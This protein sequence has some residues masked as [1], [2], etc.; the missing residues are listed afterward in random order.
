M[1]KGD[2]V[3]S[4][5]Q[6]YL[7]FLPLFFIV[8]IF[9]WWQNAKNIES[10]IALQGY[11]PVAYV[12]QK[13]EPENFGRN[14]PNAVN[15]YDKS[16]F[17]HI[18]LLVYKYL[19]IHPENL[20]PIIIGFE[21]AILSLAVYFLS[22]C[23]FPGQKDVAMLAAILIIASNV[24]EM[25]FARYG[26]PGTLGLM[27][28]YYVAESMRLFAIGM[29]LKSRT[30]VASVLLASSY[31]TYPSFGIV[32]A[33]FIFPILLTAKKKIPSIIPAVMSFLFIVLTWTLTA[34]EM[35]NFSSTSIPAQSWFDLTKLNSYHLYP[36]DYGL[37]T[38]KHEERFIQFLSFIL[39]FSFYASKIKPLRDIDRKIIVGVL[40]LIVLSIVGVIISSINLSPTLVKLSL[41][42]A[43]DLVVLT[44][45]IY[46][47]NGLWKE[48]E[49]GHLWQKIIAASI[50]ISPFV[51]K[52]G[53]PLLYSILLTLPAWNS[54]IK[55][56]RRDVRNWIVIL[57]SIGSVILLGIYAITG[58]AGKWTSVAYTGFGSRLFLYTTLLFGVL[59]VFIEALK[60]YNIKIWVTQ[61]AALL[62]I[63]GL[64]L[65]WTKHQAM[66]SEQVRL[67]SDYK[68]V[69][70]W[71]KDNTLRN[72]LF[73][74]D[75]TIYY[76]WR[77]YSQRSS[78]G[79]LREWL[80]NSW[81]YNSDA[82]AFY[83]GMKRFNEFGI[84][85]NKYIHPNPSIYKFDILSQE[86]KR[87]F[88]SLGDDW[89][90]EL[91]KKYGIDYFVLIKDEI[92]E[93]SNLKVA[94]ENEHFLVLKPE[95]KSDS[96]ISWQIIT[97]MD[98]E[99]GTPDW[100][101]YPTELSRKVAWGI[102]VESH[103]GMHSLYIKQPDKKDYWLQ[104]GKGQID[105]APSNYGDNKW[106]ITGNSKYR[107]S[108]F[109]KG[110]GTTDLYVW[111]YNAD[112]KSGSLYIGR[113]SLSDEYE[114]FVKIVNFPENAK[115]YRLSFLFRETN[116]ELSTL[117]LD[118]VKI[119][120][121]KVE[122]I[123]TE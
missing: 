57:L 51:L 46:V 71:A 95:L 30:V 13:F 114:P 9:S 37:F 15:S 58:M 21:I 108:A 101:I 99:K 19:G 81:Q 44:G 123:N 56:E 33:I 45:L 75:P 80:L 64:A 82:N 65:N 20:I 102:T 66:S 86:V 79:N 41:H 17:M 48:I 69:Q 38:T 112:G 39:L 119:E 31:I 96:K 76:G 53:F 121:M 26:Y 89:R 67:A 7:V 115:E 117:F 24:N 5:N 42:R 103:G 107:I 1:L 97:T 62:L 14:F 68:Q 36:W 50:L 6:Q 22:N 100:S 23:I 35:K 47:V 111:W 122:K 43:N 109:I 90:L 3:K 110:K 29:F 105:R 59:F 98:F 63:T 40:T 32:G 78:F 88:Y 12:H 73:M 77:D 27:L 72:A 70:L 120:K 55:R 85:I 11:S 10:T 16:A 34:F 49:S 94:Y 52:P 116:E 104:T 28:Y 106:Q 84:D 93:P 92:T 118:D 60:K 4:L 8:I 83:E 87:R 54:I 18:Y 61:L 2:R 74:Q 113:Y 25:D 91:A